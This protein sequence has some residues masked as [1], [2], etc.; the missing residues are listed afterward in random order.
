METILPKLSPSLC[1]ERV[2]IAS[3]HGRSKQ[4]LASLTSRV[5]QNAPT[6]TV[7]FILS[8]KMMHIYFRIGSKSFDYRPHRGPLSGIATS[9]YRAAESDRVEITLQFS[10]TEFQNILIYIENIKNNRKQVLGDAYP[11]QL[12]ETDFTNLETRTRG[13][14]NQNQFLK[15]DA[16]HNCL[17]W[18]TTAP[19]GEDFRSVSSLLGM[20]YSDFNQEAHSYI[21]AFYRFCLSRARSDRI[22]GIVWWTQHNE[23]QARR[24]LENDPNYLLNFYSEQTV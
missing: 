20:D 14:L 13:Q 18:F 24:I 11:L 2:F 19:I 3:L 17:T 21:V 10:P 6:R 8:L 4:D 5:C 1:K 16:K 15:S 12:S 9:D 22:A 23:E 7:S